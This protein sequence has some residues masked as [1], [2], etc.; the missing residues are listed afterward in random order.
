MKDRIKMYHTSPNKIE[1]G[2]I[3]NHGIAMDCLFFSNRIY[4][5]SPESVFLYCG[6]FHCIKAEQLHDE[7]IISEISN[8][9]SVDLD[10]GEKLLNGSINEWDLEHLNYDVLPE[11]SFFLQGA[12]GRC[13]KKMGYDGCEDIDEQGTVYIIPMKGRELEIELIDILD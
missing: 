9:F 13:A 1:N 10:T 12:R 5:M 11:L 7:E 3:H 6:Y 4:Q 8:I 2:T